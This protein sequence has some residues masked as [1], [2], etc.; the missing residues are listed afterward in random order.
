M[1]G[2][3]RDG[4]K[5]DVN[6]TQAVGGDQMADKKTYEKPEL[7]AHQNLRQVTGGAPASDQT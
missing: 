6:V 5:L 7:K 2:G 1:R 4:R 3:P